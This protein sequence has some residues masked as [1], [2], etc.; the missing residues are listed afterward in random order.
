MTHRPT[1]VL[2]CLGLAVAAAAGADDWFE[3]PAVQ[4]QPQR[5]SHVIN[6][7]QQL[8]GMLPGGRVDRVTQVMRER[9]AAQIDGVD[10]VCRLSIE[11]RRALEAAARIDAVERGEQVGAIL[12]RFAG[13]S[14]DMG[15]KEGQQKWREFSRNLQAMHRQLQAPDDRDTMLQGLIPRVLDDTQRQAWNAQEEARQRFRNQAVVAIGMSQLDANLGL[16]Q[17]Q[18]EQ[19]TEWMLSRP[20]RSNPAMLRMQPGNVVHVA[21]AALA[22]VDEKSLR[23]ILSGPQMKTILQRIQQGKAMRQHLKQQ[24]ILED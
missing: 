19:I 20:V 14:V 13:Q 3:A 11:Q 8:R 7:D 2:V 1:C 22:Q 17:A 5:Q 9:A 15:T 21:G 24:G 6:F 23:K 16:T 12:G 4:Q 10:V 18:H